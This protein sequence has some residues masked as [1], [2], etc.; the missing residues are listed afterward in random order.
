M[1]MPSTD[2]EI[3]PVTVVTGFLG[4][5]KTS[6]LL[7]LLANEAFGDTAVLVNEFGE[8]GLD[9]L[10]LSEVAPETVLLKSGCICCTI[11]GELSEALNDLFSRRQ[12]GE[13]P[14][15]KRVVLETTGLAEPAPI[16]STLAADPVTRHH[17]R[18][19][20]VVTV[21]DAVNA[22]DNHQREP[23]W[24]EQVSVADRLVLTKTDLVTDEAAQNVEAYLTTLNLV[25]P[26]IRATEQGLAADNLLII[27]DLEGQVLQ[28]VEGWKVSAVLPASFPI[29]PS[30]GGNRPE[31]L[32]HTQSFCLEFDN[33]ID[34]TVFGLWLSMLLNQHG[35][36]VLRV[37]GLLNIAGY[38]APVVI[39]GVQ[40]IVHPPIHLS[41][42]PNTDKRSRLV[43]I[44]RDLNQHT[45]ED[46]LSIFANHLQV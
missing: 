2:F 22:L 29:G 26:V 14:A 24:L 13:V 21:V 44:T 37:K 33:Q 20:G 30:V 12:R 8:V 19:A 25:A 6:L 5:G 41:H 17:F 28:E 40:H 32:S 3:I 31:H 10:L 15:F 4:S 11:R 43:F 7:Q 36:N 1:M 18:L 35:S 38:D 39:Q 34:W 9:N 16:V 46:S 42:W 27:G 23:V 45:I